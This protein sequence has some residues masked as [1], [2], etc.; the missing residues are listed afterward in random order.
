MYCDVLVALGNSTRSGSVIF[1]KNSD[2]AI[3]ECQQIRYAPHTSHRENMVKCTYISVPQASETYETVL[4]SPYWL[5]GAEMGVNEAGVVIGNTAVMSKE[6]VAREGGGLTGMDLIRLALE[7]ADTAYEA[8][9]VITGFIEKYP[10]SLYHNSFIIADPKEAWVVETAGRYWV[11][12]KVRD[13]YSISNTYTI[14]QEWDL[15][16]P[17]LVEHAVESGWCESKGEFSFAKVYADF[18]VEYMRTAQLRLRRTRRLLEK[19]RGRIDL[20]YLMRVMRDHGEDTLVGSRWAGN[21][22]FFDTVCVHRKSETAASMIVELADEDNVFLRTTCWALL[23]SPCTSVY[24]PLFLG[25]VGV[26]EELGVGS[27]KYSEGSTWWLFERLQRLVDTSYKALA[28]LVRSVWDYIEEVEVGE[29]RLLRLKLKA[30]LS[31]GKLEECRPLLQAFVRKNFERITA[32]A[33]ELEQ[34]IIK[35]NEIL[36][37]YPNLRYEEIERAN[38]EANLTLR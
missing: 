19:G 22:L 27:D 18:N 35:L 28:P 31:E 13:T 9:E 17:K 29:V 3:N 16:H 8:L 4:F 7:R 20:K 14:E 24:F 21:E 33:R 37:S 5:W 36:P 11:A 15:A 34:L 30:M 25:G 38:E 32:L 10:Q 1:A 2:R 6:P 23:S 26:P 12:K